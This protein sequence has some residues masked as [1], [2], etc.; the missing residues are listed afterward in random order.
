MPSVVSEELGGRVREVAS[1][2]G[3]YLRRQGSY[4]NIDFILLICSSGRNCFGAA[5]VISRRLIAD[6]GS[7]G[8]RQAF[9]PPDVWC[10]GQAVSC[11]KNS[12]GCV[13]VQPQIIARLFTRPSPQYVMRRNVAEGRDHVGVSMRGEYNSRVRKS[14]SSSAV[15]CERP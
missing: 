13:L 15:V 12:A 7:I 9:G 1:W 3:T 2:Q 8:S 5:V 4:V 11:Q 10:V 6:C 14:R